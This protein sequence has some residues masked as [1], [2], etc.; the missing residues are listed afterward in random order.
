MRF[1]AALTL[2]VFIAT[3]AMPP[4]PARAMSTSAEISLGEGLSKQVD[5]ES[6]LVTDPFLT[7]WVTGIGDKLA[8]YR[9]RQDITYRFTVINSDEI[10]AFALPGGFIHV[11]LGLM[12]TV[13]SDDELASVMAHEMGHVE[14]RHVV[15][16]N[17][18]GN[19][20]SI[21]IGVLS[22]LSPIAYLF[23]G[24]GGDLLFNKFSRQDELQADQYGLLLMSRAGYDPRSMV[25]MME[26]LADM[27]GLPQSKAD[28]AFANHPP[29][30]DRVAHL[31]GYPQLDKPNADQLTQQGLHDQEEGRLSYA[32]VRLQDA[33]AARSANALA[34]E[35]LAEVDVALKADEAAA[36]AGSQLALAQAAAWDATRRD[37]ETNLAEATSVTNNDAAL[38]REQA[39]AGN[40]DVET[41]FNQLNS[42]SSAVPNMGS[43][44]KEG[45]NLSVALAGLDHI[46]RDVNGTLGLTSDVLGTAPQLLSDNRALLSDLAKPLRESQPSPR[47]LAVLPSYGAMIAGVGAAS[48]QLVR[49]SG[50][51]RAAISMGTDAAHLLNDYLVVLNSLDT[52]KGDIDPK[53]MPKVQ[54]AMDKAVGAWDGVLAMAQRSQDETYA[55]Q[56]RWLS[57]Q[58][59]LLD[60]T[61]SRA[62]Y[63]AFARVLAFRFPGIALPDYGTVAGLGVPAGEVACSAWL[64][65]E[66][67]QPAVDLIR[68]GQS[69]GR[70]C[71]DLA[72]DK[73]LM[74]ESMEIAV[75][76]VYQDYIDKPH[77]I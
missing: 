62:R 35:H 44:K 29:P 1:I 27:E 58:I 4:A 77:K 37:L 30:K 12:N 56:T 18:K 28:K 41:F 46:A 9:E 38:V 5:R 69:S 39:K 52:T 68:Q 23:G 70:S 65:F 40:N 25:D 19:L 66:T 57:A 45:N 17:Q 36:P 22:I 51:A 34:S 67:K 2:S 59:T 24:Y 15:T 3:I 61:S 71:V 20:L 7:T 32:Q 50:H 73:Q 43:P 14:R 11:D 26:R 72:L 48:D 54:A 75:G 21:L 6:L 55:A 13:S 10:N 64:A 42:L 53:D 33:L 76:L 31:M 63:D 16:L 8:K 47:T 49:S 74:A 60:M